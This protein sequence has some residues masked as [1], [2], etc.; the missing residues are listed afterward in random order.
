VSTN[1]KCRPD[2]AF[3]KKKL[4]IFVDGCFWHQCPEH[5]HIPSNNNEYWTRKLNGNRARDENDN[6]LLTENGWAVLRIWE[7]MP[8]DKALLLVD[9]SYTQL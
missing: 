2:V 6:E 9:S 3:T 7:H 5:G 8:L 1:R 4:A